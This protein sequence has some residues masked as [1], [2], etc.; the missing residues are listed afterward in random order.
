VA[1]PLPV[2]AAVLAVARAAASAVTRALAAAMAGDVGEF[3]EGTPFTSSN[4]DRSKTMITNRKIIAA[5]LS[6]VL[7]GPAW[8]TPTTTHAAGPPAKSCH[9]GSSACPVQPLSAAEPDTLTFMREEEKLAR[10]IYL[11]LD[12][13]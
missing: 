4:Q 11:T 8:L 7:A 6:L 13:K 2:L 3:R 5:A 12:Q 10:D 9:P 1:A